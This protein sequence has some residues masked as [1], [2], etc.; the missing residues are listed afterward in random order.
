MAERLGDEG[1]HT[2][3]RLGGS[4]ANEVKKLVFRAPQR[5]DD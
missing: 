5:D 3:I 2:A 4:A 1:F